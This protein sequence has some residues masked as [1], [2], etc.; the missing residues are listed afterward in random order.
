MV[1]IVILYYNIMGPPSYMQSVVDRNVVMR[2]I[3]VNVWQRYQE[4]PTVQHIAPHLET[5]TQSELGIYYYTDPQIHYTYIYIYI[6]SIYRKNC[7]MFRYICITFRQSDP[8]C[9]LRIHCIE[10]LSS[11][12]VQNTR[13]V[14]I[15]IYAASVVQR[16]RAGL[17]YPSSRV[18]TRPK[19]SDF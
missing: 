7:Y 18:Q 12:C 5:Q 11:A 10:A 13:I 3:T 4:L 19:P 8:L 16:Q 15:Y 2:R 14:Y 1:S 6:Y 17:W 9:L